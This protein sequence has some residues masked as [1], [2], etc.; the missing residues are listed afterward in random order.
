ME[1]LKA[2]RCSN[3]PSL[4]FSPAPEKKLFKYKGI[5]M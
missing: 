2:R 3:L 1:E 5:T 4:A